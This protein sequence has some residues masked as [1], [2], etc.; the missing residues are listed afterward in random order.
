LATL[1]ELLENKTQ[2]TDDVKINLA[3]GVYTTLGEVRK[4]YMMESD[5]RKKTSAVSEARRELDRDRQQFEAARIDAEV[6]L[7][8]LAA[9]LLKREPDA[10]QSDLERELQANPVAKAL[11]D[12][13][14]G[15][16]EKLSKLEEAT[17][18][19]Y[20]EV[21]QSKQSAMVDQHRRVL[22]EIQSRDADADPAEIV[23]YAK[24]N[25]VPRLDLAY[26]L[27]SEEKRMKKAV[28]DAKAEAKTAGIEEGRRLAIAPTLPQHARFLAP[29]ADKDAPKS[30]DEAADRALQDPEILGL[31]SQRS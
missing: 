19:L 23:T 25:Y 21:K 30:F 12:Q 14:K 4:G 24:T 20:E 18:G 8:S 5:Y 11:A 22:A 28:E 16:N 29:E 15:L 9:K 17:G 2:Y 27:L 1:Q 26:R 13:V 7:E 31:L 6:K 10:S 3:D